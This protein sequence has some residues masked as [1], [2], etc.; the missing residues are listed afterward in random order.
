MNTF[1]RRRALLTLAAAPVVMLTS[2][3]SFPKPNAPSVGEAIRYLCEEVF[4]SGHQKREA[5]SSDA[6]LQAG[7]C[8]VH[9]LAAHPCVSV[10][11]A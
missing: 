7:G 3:P 4:P 2:S 5:L 1:S 11:R 9:V 8:P 6:V 10:G